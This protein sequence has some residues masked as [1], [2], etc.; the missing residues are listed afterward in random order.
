[1]SGR[2]LMTFCCF[3]CARLQQ[4]IIHVITHNLML[5]NSILSGMNEVSGFIL[6]P[7]F[8]LLSKQY[9]HVNNS[10]STLLAMNQ[11]LASNGRSVAQ[12]TPD[13][14]VHYQQEIDRRDA[15]GGGVVDVLGTLE[16]ICQSL[17]LDW[18][19]NNTAVENDFIAALLHLLKEDVRNIQVL[20]VACL[21]QLSMRKLDKHQW[22][23]LISS[24]PSALFEASNAAAQRARERGLEPNSIDM[25]VDQL[26]FHRSLSKMGSTLISA[27]L[28]HI[29]ADKDILS[30]RGAK[31]DVVSSYLQL[32]SEMMSHQS[33]V[34]CGYQ[35]NM[36]VGLLR[37]PAIVRRNFVVFQIPF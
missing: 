30:G 14:R 23:R 18:V 10:K 3:H 26:E 6:I 35:V 17:P 27:H 33:G 20:S 24:L 29:T 36:W 11:Y 21:K 9:G 12:M 28:A 8:E 1:M 22:Y 15:A 34:I 2:N 13:E 37:D 5:L 16:K 4:E 32:L 7:L 31:F 19:F 25:L